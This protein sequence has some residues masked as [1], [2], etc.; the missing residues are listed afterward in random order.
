MQKLKLGIPAGSLQ[1]ATLQLFAKAGFNITVRERSYC[2][3]IDDE[4][5]ECTLIRAQEI[6]RYVQ[7]GTLDLGLSGK[8]WIT[9]NNA[10]VVEVSELRYSKMSR[11]PIRFVMAVPENSPIKSVKDLEGKKIATELVNVTKSYLKKNKVN[12]EVEFSW[13][14]TEVKPPKLVDAIAELTET[15]SS[16][17]ANNLRI[18]DTIMESTT[19][20][21]ANKKS[22]A[23]KWK[24]EKIDDI[25]LLLK[26]AL[27]AEGKVG[28]KM[29]IKESTLE[30]ITKLVP[31]TKSPTVSPLK[32]KGWVAIEVIMDEKQVRELI[33][34]LRKLGAQGI[35]EYPLN[36]VI[37]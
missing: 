31:G 19:R 12:A 18:L 21:I 36:K 16:L 30:E 15:G 35:V 5:I 37:Q 17:R 23:D 29:N 33:P 1:A 9:E 26:S 10:D 8:D 3:S 13:G 34:R 2:P 24:K 7:D 14:A 32:L 27:D 20:L 11:S 22:Y 4:E 25:A 28:L 6:P